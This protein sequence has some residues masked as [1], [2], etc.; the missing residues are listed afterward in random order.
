ML[1]KKVVFISAQ[2]DVPYFHWQV[3]VM[4]HNFINVGINPNWIEV[5]WAHNGSPSPEL[6]ALA[7]KYPYVRFFSYTKSVK[8]NFGYIPILRPDILEQHFVK[9]PNLRGETIFYHDS[10]I[11]FR[12]LPN[13]D[14]MHG[15]LFWYFSDTISYIGSDYIRSKGEDLFL[16]MC[17]IANIDPELV[18]FNQNNSGGA[19]HLM[20]GVTAD[21]WKSVKQDALALYRFMAERETAE[22]AK[23]IQEISEAKQTLSAE[24]ANSPVL[25]TEE[26]VNAKMAEIDKRLTEYNPNQK[27]RAD[28]W[29]V[30]WNAMKLGAQPRISKEFS[31]SWGTSTLTE[32]ENHNIMHNAGVTNNENGTLFYKGEFINQNPFEADFSKIKADSAS[33]KYVEA[34]LY[35]KQNR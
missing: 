35:A 14:S 9:F 7:N 19:Q 16:E 20:K 18:K 17:K 8:D 24:V 32:Y 22:R 28:M 29:A 13:F 3:E 33:A 34:I 4:I 15:D 31:F 2:P 21:Y 27:W 12:Q 6:T 26:W 5:L 25:L 23:R 1:T 30:L 11:I 10:D